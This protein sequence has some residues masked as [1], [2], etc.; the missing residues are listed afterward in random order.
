M[1]GMEILKIT[2]MSWRKTMSDFLKVEEYGHDWIYVEIKSGIR[3]IH[4]P[5]GLCCECTAYRGQYRNRAMAQK[6]IQE[7]LEQNND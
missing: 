5:S 3:V 4:I 7:Q 2:R 1:V 6:A